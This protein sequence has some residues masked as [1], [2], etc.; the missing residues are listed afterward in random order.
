MVRG[1]LLFYALHPHSLHL[2]HEIEGRA[3]R[4]T[5]DVLAGLPL[6]APK[7]SARPARSILTEKRTDRTDTAI[8]RPPGMA[9]YWP[10]V[11]PF[12]EFAPIIC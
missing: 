12:G 8:S 3:D 4:A 5:S 11:T 1:L 6:A 9:A 7:G 2:Q 10:P